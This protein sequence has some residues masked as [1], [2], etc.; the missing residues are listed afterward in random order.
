MPTLR[1]EARG[2]IFDATAVP[3]SQAISYMTSLA[4][5]KSGTI[6]AGWQNGKSKH[7]A[8][9]TIRLARSFDGGESWDVLP[10]SFSTQWQGVPGS[11]ATSEMVE[12]EPGRLLLFTTWFDRSQPER[13]LFNPETEGIL[14]SK[15]LV[16][17]SSD[18]GDTW[19]DWREVPIPNLTGCAASGPAITWPDGTVAF[20]FESFKEWDDPAPAEFAA[21]L[22][23]S[24]DG[25]RSFEQPWQ[26]AQ[27]PAQ[28]IYHW[29]E[30]L[31]PA[32]GN[33]DFVGMFWTHNRAEQRDMNV[34]LLRASLSDGDRAA[35]QPIETG[36]PGQIAA[37]CVTD[38]GRLLA[39]VVDR[40]Q[41]G[42]LTLWQSADDGQTW[43]A[44]SRLIVHTHDERAAVTQGRDN[45]DFG[46][47]WEDMGKWSFGHP[48]IRPVAGG[49]LLAW[50]A[51]SPDRMSVHWA[52]VGEEL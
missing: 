6:M 51:G 7:D 27:D 22:C 18:E 25:G 45:I 52:R 36:I 5:L 48:V 15:Q 24:R 47:F 30:R 38:D 26:V 8:L 46:E 21:W 31:C 28:K 4:V 40:D 20:A 1:V 11:L 32:S 23:V 44:E 29:D 2:T 39:F 35:R 16:A 10:V 43:P 3:E 12:P 19:S 17:V 42:T 9:N 34:H 13:P 50:Y 14:G 49:W 37:P 41:P 33:G